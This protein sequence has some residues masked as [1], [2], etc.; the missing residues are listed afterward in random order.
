VE[1]R[2]NWSHSLWNHPR[3]M[4]PG[5]RNGR[6]WK[7]NTWLRRQG[8]DAWGRGG[9]CCK[10]ICR[11]PVILQQGATSI[12]ILGIHIK[13]TGSVKQPLKVGIVDFHR[14]QR[15]NS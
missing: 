7:V 12:N 15:G 13:F 4:G 5:S 3:V 9:P 1:R 10:I 6:I 11:E 14:S 2:Q 8:K